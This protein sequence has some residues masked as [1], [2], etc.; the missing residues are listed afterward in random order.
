MR[1]SELVALLAADLEAN[2]DTENVAIG[3]TIAGTDGQKYRLDAFIA[4]SNDVE[5]IRDV[6][7]VNGLACVIADYKGQHE[8]FV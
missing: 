8:V 7:C 5:V 4:A 3:V 6:N 1:Y 2:G